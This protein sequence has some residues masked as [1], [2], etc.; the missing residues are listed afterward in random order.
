MT[1]AKK[2]TIVEKFEE[3]VGILR[4]LGY[5]EE[6]K[7]IEERKDLHEKKN[8]SR[9]PTK[10]QEENE[11]IK[12]AILDFMEEGKPYT[13]TDIQKA[14]GLD[15]NQKTSALMRQLKEADLVIRSEVKGKA[16]FTKA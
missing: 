4:S 6:A 3:V 11:A 8:T 5:E 7:F 1:M 15:S 10:A 16:Y 12:T 9:K 14:I 13:I 2:V